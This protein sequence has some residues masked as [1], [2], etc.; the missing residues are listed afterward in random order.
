MVSLVN[1]I[2]FSCSNYKRT[3]GYKINVGRQITC[4]PILLSNLYVESGRSKFTFK[5]APVARSASTSGWT[6]GDGV[7]SGGGGAGSSCLGPILGLVSPLGSSK[8][9]PLSGGGDGSSCLGPILGLVASGESSKKEPAL[10]VVQTPPPAFVLSG[11]MAASRIR[12][13]PNL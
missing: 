6:S 2:W 13:M 4:R 12:D 9:E 3:F 7:A 10:G 5:S 11:L 1:I 8:N